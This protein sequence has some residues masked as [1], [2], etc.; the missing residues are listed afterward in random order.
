MDV[1]PR[2]RTHRW[3]QAKWVPYRHSSNR[4]EFA[5]KSSGGT[6]ALE[7]ALKVLEAVGSAAQG[8]SQ[9]QIAEQVQ[10]PRTTLHRILGSLVNRGMIH[11]CAKSTGWVS[12][13]EAGTQRLLKPDLVVAASV[14]LRA[15]RHLTAVTSYLAVLDGNHVMSLGVATVPTPRVLPPRWGKASRCIALG[16][17]RLFSAYCPKSDCETIFKGLTMTELIP[18]TLTDRR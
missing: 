2:T 11:R 14:E 18:H 12:A 9:A 5:K 4:W 15:L 3:K 7:R 1:D 8:L 13:I 17:A 16:R 10:L 6:A